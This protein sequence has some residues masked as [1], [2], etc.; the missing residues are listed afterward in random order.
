MM[1]IPTGYGLLLL[2]FLSCYVQ[3]RDRDVSQ[4]H[5]NQDSLMVQVNRAEYFT[6]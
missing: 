5:K 1:Y 6:F 2:L 3:G 4:S